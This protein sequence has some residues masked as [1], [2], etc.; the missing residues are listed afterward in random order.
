MS[1]RYQV[2]VLGISEKTMFWEVR[3]VSGEIPGVKKDLQK[4][5]DLGDFRV[6][7]P[8]FLRHSGFFRGH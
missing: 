4:A 2:K 8:G 7:S 6:W 3:E 5:A 1:E